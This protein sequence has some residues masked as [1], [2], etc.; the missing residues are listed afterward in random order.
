MFKINILNMANNKKV[1]IIE[2]NGIT[3]S[4]RSVDALTE[5]IKNLQKLIN[6]IGNIKIPI[7]I[8]GDIDKLV[9]QINQVKTKVSKS[10]TNKQQVKDEQELV[11]A[12]EQ[13]K[14]VLQAVNKELG[15]T[16][17]N[18]EEFKQETKALVAEAI[19]ARNEAEGYANTL[20]GLKKE[21]KDLN[22][23]KGDIDLGSEEYTQISQRIYEITQR[24]KEYEAA[25]G[26]HGRNVG[27]YTESILDA[28]KQMDDFS[29]KAKDTSDNV[30]AIKEKFERIKGVELNAENVKK[31]GISISDLKWQI[32]N[33]EKELDGLTIGSDEW[34]ATN[35]SLLNLKQTLATVQRD[36]E[37]AVRAEDQLNTKIKLNINGM[38]L[39][40]D[41]VNQ[42]VGIL[43]DKMYALAAAGKRDTKEFQDMAK[44]AS[45]LK[46][47]VKSV[48]TQIDAMAEGGGGINKML[49]YAQGFSALATASQGI[50]QLFGNDENSAKGVQTM[51]ALIG[52]MESLRVV[53]QEM[54]QGTKFGKMLESW[55]N[56]FQALTASLE[57]YK[58]SY[59]SMMDEMVKGDKN[60]F[61]NA[62]GLDFTKLNQTIALVNDL[63]KEYESLHKI[64]SDKAG[65]ELPEGIDSLGDAFATLV[66][67]GK[68]TKDE[69]LELDE[70]LNNLF[71]SSNKLSSETRTL[72]DTFG[73]FKGNLSLLGQSLKKFFV[74]IGQGIKHLF[75]WKSATAQAGIG[76]AQ[77]SRGL[78]L[79]TAGVKGLTVAAKGLSMALKAIIIFAIIDALMKLVGWL[80]DAVKWVYEFATGNDKLVDSLT[81]VQ[82]RLDVTTRS[83]DKFITEIERLKDSGTLTN[84]EADALIIEKLKDT[85]NESIKSLQK[86]I[87][88]RDEFKSLE[89]SSNDDDYTLFGIASDIDGIDEAE[90][91]VKEFEKTYTKLLDAV[92]SGTDE[93]GKRGKGWFNFDIFNWFTTSDAKADLGEMQ[94]KVIE[95][96]QYRINNLDLSK[97]TGEL[98]KFLNKIDT[99]MYAT[100]LAN[101]ENLYPEEDWAKVLKERLDAVREMY[102]QMDDLSAKSKNEQI[103]NQKD[104]AK[105]IRNNNTEAIEDSYQREKKQLQDQREDEIEA[106]K[107]N[108]KLII[109]I[110][111]KYNRLEQDLVDQHNKD[112]KSKREKAAADAKKAE[113]DK[114][115]ALKAIRDNQLA[116][117][118]ESLEKRIKMLEN[119]KEEELRDAEKNGIMVGELRLSIEAKYNKLIQ[120]EREN[121][122]KF[123]ND[124]AEEY[125][126]KELELKQAL[127]ENELDNQS[128]RIDINYEVSSFQ[129]S[130]DFDAEYGDKIQAEKEFAKQRLE[131]ELKYLADKKKLD[132]DKTNLNFDNEVIDEE[133]RYKDRLDELKSFLDEG[134][135]N[136]QE[137][138]RFVEQ[139]SQLHSSKLESIETQR[140]NELKNIN[141]KYLN[142]VKTETSESLTSTVDLY[143][144]YQRKVSDIMEKV[145]TDKNIFGVTSFAA[146]KKKLKEAYDTVKEGLAKIDEEMKDLEKKHNN[147]QITFIDYKKAKESLEEK[148]KDLKKDGAFIK[149][150]MKDFIKDFANDWKGVLD[151]YVGMISS[152]LQTLNET[153]LQLI[154][155]ELAQVE[156]QLEI[157]QDAY[158]KAE[159]AAEAHKDKMDSIE[160]ELADARGSRRQFLIDTLA[161]Q[162]SAYLEELDA[163]Q[164]AEKQKEKLEK[165]Q[166]ALEKKRKEQ[167]KKGKVQQAI[168]NTYMSV[169]NALAV[170]PWF[171]GLALSAVALGLGLKNVMAIKSTPIYE[172]GGVIQGKRHSQ[173]G[174][175]V[176]GGQAEVE[177]GEFITNRKSTAA[178]LPLLTYINDKKKTLTAEDL[179]EFFSN[180][181]PRIKSRATN[182]FANGG[183]LPTT[184]GAEVTR[185]V[186]VAEIAEDNTT[187]VVSVIDI[188]NATDNLK[189]VQVLSGLA[190]K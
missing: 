100:S 22:N 134:K 70:R 173:G 43:E 148:K 126:R 50:S 58:K 177:G 42:A 152:F 131:I 23:I 1:F 13:R 6:S 21:L 157:Q 18:S 135:L 59:T 114:Y 116:V 93:S 38:N 142:D 155:N 169:S 102:E 26:S 178:N 187:Y 48:D 89:E 166:E 168:I 35:Q 140:T 130:Y 175:K 137:Y 138:N 133:Q 46:I 8:G 174:V 136:N 163:Q 45:D 76:T 25:M 94:K 65:K 186:N 14:K 164:E 85:L 156:H 10:T 7:S 190:D 96:I 181:T 161:A 107:G 68:I 120:N 160:D 28:T 113:E 4:V 125:A 188:L 2:I 162:Q 53:S 24:L 73:T 82:S 122:L 37:A 40:F 83:V 115:N 124:L 32:Q 123:L 184:N 9:K 145:G 165:R 11:K 3:E 109:S 150:S 66:E 103:K 12:L 87:K 105:Q 111:K 69:F 16:G 127:K 15:T 5:K 80:T 185:V 27:N 52:V 143:S 72:S 118:S 34:N 104:I 158:D 61:N 144:E 90:K 121:H 171:L 57:S 151:S 39:V 31:Y 153:K 95:D 146:T 108:Q 112:L 154:D 74:G 19:K 79:A 98:E 44:A 84:L 29:K 62:L 172:D 49:S 92:E 60:A 189:K 54:Q 64:L 182:K 159:A 63:R 91:R 67:E 97:G 55:M 71:E 139:E 149:K 141:D 17:K 20:N 106:A 41:D 170:Q 128:K 86:F 81:T 75:T 167:E 36:M 129:G 30:D 51:T 179:L 47:Q 176:L 78:A 110:K 33:L 180:G 88:L 99:E 132:E 77:M 117:E 101:I 183:Q 119:A 147:G 56:K